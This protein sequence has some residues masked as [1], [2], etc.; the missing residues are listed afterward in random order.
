[1]E[2][3][4]GNH[5]CVVETLKLGGIE[6]PNKLSQL[7]LAQ[8]D[9]FVAVYAA[10]MQ[11]SFVQSDIYLRCESEARRVHGCTD[12][13]RESRID[14]GL[15]ADYDEHAKAL[16]VTRSRPHYTVEFAAPHLFT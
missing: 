5:H 3:P 4:E 16:R 2:H 12:D 7:R 15:S 13:R 9:K 14:Q 11:K 6:A 8:A 1:M 10:F